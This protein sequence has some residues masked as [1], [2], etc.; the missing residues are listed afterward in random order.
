HF[1]NAE[2]EK[3]VNVDQFYT[4]HIFENLISNAIKFSPVGK[5]VYVHLYYEDEKLKVE[6]KDEGPGI[7]PEDMKKIFRKYQKLSARPTAGERSTGLGLSIVKK[8]VDLMNGKVW[9]KS[10]LGQGSTF[11]VEFNKVKTPVINKV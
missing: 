9:C 10:T 4:K 6:I 2:N 8:Y 1:E 11:I 3:E 5:N 7:S